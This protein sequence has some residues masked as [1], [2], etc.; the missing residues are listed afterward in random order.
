MIYVLS[1]GKHVFETFLLMRVQNGP[2]GFEKTQHTKRTI[3]L[4]NNDHLVSEGLQRTNRK[5]G[6][7]VNLY[8]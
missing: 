6:K 7:I 5:T 2:V 8:Q 4:P 1:F 3:Y